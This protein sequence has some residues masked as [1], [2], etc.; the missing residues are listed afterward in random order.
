MHFSELHIVSYINVKM[1]T[2]TVPEY[3]M[4]V[5]YCDPFWQLPYYTLLTGYIAGLR[6]NTTLWFS[7]HLAFA[8]IKASIKVVDA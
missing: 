4:F 3:A 8:S 7:T 2:E 1:F 5:F 6:M